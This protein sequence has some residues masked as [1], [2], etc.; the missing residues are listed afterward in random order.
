MNRALL[1][2]M[3]A[4]AVTGCSTV[5][6]SRSLNDPAV[7]ARTIAMQVCSNCHGVEGNAESPNFPNLAGQTK[8]YLVEQLKSFRSHDR[9]DPA[10]F[11]YMW[12]MT[13]HL[14]DQQI[15]GLAA[16]YAA[17]HP[18]ANAPADPKLAAAGREIVEKGVPA[19]NVPPCAS[20]H[21]ANGEGK[22]TFPRLADQHGDY[23]IKQLV[24]F[25]RT[26]ER[27]QGSVM[28]TVAHGLSPADMEQVA[29]YLQS[30]ATGH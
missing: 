21:G 1:G 29:A 28:K 17:Q 5:E 9:S 14:T 8:P 24:V 12:G 13:R 18:V 7:P 2:V 11:E 15:E 20:C 25:Q 30:V 6:R 26:D 16:Y 22:D 19:R 3:V 27:P 4:V 10:G 23:L